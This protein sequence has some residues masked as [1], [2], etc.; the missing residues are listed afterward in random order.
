MA[1][2]LT[3]RDVLPVSYYASSQPIQWVSSD[4]AIQEIDAPL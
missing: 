1:H 3:F 4:N 2:E